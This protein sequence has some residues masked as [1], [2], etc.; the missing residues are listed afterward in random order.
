[1]VD[2]RGTIHSTM[3]L[4][5]SKSIVTTVVQHYDRRDTIDSESAFYYTIALHKQSIP[6]ETI[7]IWHSSD[8]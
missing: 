5:P 6:V 8:Q 4:F 2:A 3:T 7:L 1:M